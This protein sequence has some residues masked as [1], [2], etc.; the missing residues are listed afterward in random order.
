MSIL[1]LPIAQLCSNSISPDTSSIT[2]AFTTSSSHTRPIKLHEPRHS[3]AWVDVAKRWLQMWD[4]MRQPWLNNRSTSTDV[5]VQTCITISCRSVM[6]T[7]HTWIRQIIKGH[8]VEVRIYLLFLIPPLH[9][10]QDILWQWQEVEFQFVNKQWGGQGLEHEEVIKHVSCMSQLLEYLGSVE[11]QVREWEIIIEET[12][13]YPCLQANILNLI[14]I[15][16]H[17]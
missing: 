12:N 9:S 5:P 6:K 4:K 3:K 11:N 17:L 10:I 13:T 14:T 1:R 15:Q 8:A 16:R 2:L 7:K